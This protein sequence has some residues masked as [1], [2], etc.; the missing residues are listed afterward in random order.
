MYLFVERT[1]FVSTPLDVAA[2]FPHPVTFYAPAVSDALTPVT[3]TWFHDG[4]RLVSDDVSVY[5]DMSGN[6]TVLQTGQTRLGEYKCVASNGISSVSASARLYLPADT[7]AP[8]SPLD[9]Q[10]RAQ[11]RVLRDLFPSPKLSC[12]VPQ[13]DRT[14]SATSFQPMQNMLLI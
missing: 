13:R 8:P 11:G 2:E 6:L 7:G 14:A 1:K 4:H 10:S 5:V 12:I 9:D 3:Y